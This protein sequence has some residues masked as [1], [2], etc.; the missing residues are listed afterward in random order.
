MLRAHFVKY[1][2]QIDIKS[3]DVSDYYLGDEKSRKIKA[4][5]KKGA[6]NAWSPHK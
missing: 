4:H 5:K 3:R 1:Y 2:L 6:T